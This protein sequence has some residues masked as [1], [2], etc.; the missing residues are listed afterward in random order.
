MQPPELGQ[1]AAVYRFALLGGIV[2]TSE[3][4]A[5]ADAWIWRLEQYPDAL[6]EVSV[7]G[8]RPNEL[9]SAIGELAER[10]MSSEPL[11]TLLGLMSEYL[12]GRP[13][14]F[15]I[16]TQLLARLATEHA[17]QDG[18][19]LEAASFDDFLTLADD[20]I[21]DPLDVQRD[22]LAFLKRHSG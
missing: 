4:I 6:V 12:S 8:S 13:T 16:V 11:V 18:L 22:V 15:R 20:G 7:N 19:S 9:L 1:E 17:L 5:W 3:V 21:F 2:E 10:P 14:G